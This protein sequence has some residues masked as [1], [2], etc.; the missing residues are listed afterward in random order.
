MSNNK[1]TLKELIES[2]KHKYDNY[3]NSSCSEEWRSHITGW[4]YAYRDLEKI[5]EQNGFDMEQIVKGDVIN[6]EF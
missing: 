5:L 6:R 4:F 1:M 3:A 2:R